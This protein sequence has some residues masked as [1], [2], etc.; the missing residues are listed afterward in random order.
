MATPA[1]R[2]AGMQTK[3]LRLH[4]AASRQAGEQQRTN[5]P[6]LPTP[7][8]E[9]TLAQIC[10]SLPAKDD[11]LSSFAADTAAK[12][13]QSQRAIQVDARRGSKIVP[14]VLDRIEG[15]RGVRRKFATNFRRRFAKV[16]RP[17]LCWCRRSGCAGEGGNHEHE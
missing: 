1:H 2:L 11:N 6:L 5:C 8:S 9:G 17:R 15:G 16:A 7:Q 10:T 4:T 13:G 3:S 14:D 12:T